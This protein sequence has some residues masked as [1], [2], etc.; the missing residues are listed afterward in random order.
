LLSIIIIIKYY[1]TI[2]K[3]IIIIVVTPLVT[4]LVPFL[5]T[6]YTSDFW[7]NS[8]S[9]HIQK[10]FDDI[11]WWAVVACVRGRQE[12]E[13]G[14]LVE[15]FTNWT[16]KNCLPLNTTK[17]K[18]QRK[19]WTLTETR[20]DIFFMNIRNYHELKSYV[21]CFCS[22]LKHFF[23]SLAECSPVVT[24]TSYIEDSL[25]LNFLTV[26]ISDSVLLFKSDE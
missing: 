4:V 25:D 10:Y 8:E 26:R 14:D 23:S 21:L 13:Y 19:T 20:W 16:K 18:E 6:L 17:T 7:Y 5:F 1:Y 12:G 22:L 9:C 24:V 2:L 15:A 3:Y 11:F